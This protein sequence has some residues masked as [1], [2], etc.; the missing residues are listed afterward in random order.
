[1]IQSHG[2]DYAASE[3]LFSKSCAL[4]K[5]PLHILEK[6]LHCTQTTLSM[7][8]SLSD[9]TGLT[10]FQSVCILVTV[11]LISGGA[12]WLSNSSWYE[13]LLW[14]IDMIDKS[15][16]GPVSSTPCACVLRHFSRVQLFWGQKSSVQ[17]ILDRILCPWDSPGKNTGMGCHFLLQGIFLTQGSNL[18]LLT[19]PALASRFFT[20]GATWE[21]PQALW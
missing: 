6:K 5:V 16:N 20:T 10:E 17:G 8:V 3:P 4:S 14:L 1:M 7:T 11:T 15:V 21:A 18:H 13:R 2:Y 19:S 12:L 9:N